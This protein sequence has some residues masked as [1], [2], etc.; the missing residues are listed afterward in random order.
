MMTSEDLCDFLK[1]SE[2]EKAR[3]DRGGKEEDT[4][5]TFDPDFRLNDIS[6]GFRIFA[7][8]DHTTQFS[9]KHY[10]MPN[11]E[12]M[13]LDVYLHA[14][15]KYPGEA[16]AEM[17]L[18]LLVRQ[19]NETK[20]NV[21]LLLSFSN[22]DIYPSFN[23][24]ILG[25]LLHIAQEVPKDIPLTVHCSSNLLGNVLVTNRVRCEG[26]PLDP[27]YPLI[28]SVISALQERTG[29]VFFQKGRPQPCKR[30]I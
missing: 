27:L 29:R 26:D 1:L 10:N 14:K 13:G 23:S 19:D 2:A 16:R 15:I 25:G 11:D 28:K 12:K 6:H 24:A 22:E 30:H 8:E 18:M 3:N 21:S 7:I 9:T 5:L 17:N 20:M 4:P